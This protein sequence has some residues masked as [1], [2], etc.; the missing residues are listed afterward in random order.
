MA[1][2]HRPSAGETNVKR[3][4]MKYKKLSVL[5]KLIAAAVF[6]IT[7]SV[8]T[9]AQAEPTEHLLSASCL[10]DIKAPFRRQLDDDDKRDEVRRDFHAPLVLTPATGT[11]LAEPLVPVNGT[12]ERIHLAYELLFN[13]VTPD[14]VRIHSLQVVDPTRNNQSVGAY[15]VFAVDGIEI[16]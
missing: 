7:E 11:V 6:A 14:L 10:D 2:E 15:R 13:N 9:A 8:I 3:E 4:P 12:D 5:L 16:T 1:A